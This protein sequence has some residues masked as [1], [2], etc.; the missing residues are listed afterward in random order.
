MEQ[1]DD[2]SHY[3]KAEKKE[4]EGAESLMAESAK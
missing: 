1:A 2:K 3:A 4:R